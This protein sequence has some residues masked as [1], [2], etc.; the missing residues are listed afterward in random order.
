MSITQAIWDVVKM[1]S[2]KKCS[3][4][5]LKNTESWILRRRKCCG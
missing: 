5:S 4:V 3:L 2:M 1:L